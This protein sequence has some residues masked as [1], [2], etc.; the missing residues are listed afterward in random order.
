MDVPQTYKTAAACNIVGGALNLLVN[1]MW[2][3]SLIMSCMGVILAPLS[4]IAMAIGAWQIMVGIKMNNGERV[5]NAEMVSIAGAVIGLFS[6]SWISLGT[7]AFAYL[8]L[9]DD[10]SKLYL[11]G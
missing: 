2:T 11:Q 9:Q 10:E 4:M 6:F 1:G 5:G 8:Q 7:G 3:I